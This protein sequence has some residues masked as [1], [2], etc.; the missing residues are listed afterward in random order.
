[1]QVLTR[2]LKHPNLLKKQMRRKISHHPFEDFMKKYSGQEWQN[3]IAITVLV[4]TGFL[5]SR[6]HFGF[7]WCLIVLAFGAQYYTNSVQRHRRNVRDDITRQL[8]I[9]KLFQDA[10][11]TEWLN[12]FVSKFW[13]IYEPVLSAMVVEIADGILAE[14][15]PG[16][17]DSLR[18]SHFTLGTKAPRVDSVKTLD[19]HDDEKVE[20]EWEFS[21]TPNDIIDMTK[22]ELERK[23]NPKICL[24]IRVGKGFVGAGIPVLVEDFAFKGR[25]RI[26]L[27]LMSTF[28]HVRT[29]D[30]SFME[31]P[32]IDYVLKPIGGETF[33][34]DIAHVPG[35]QTFI[36]DQT[37]AVL[38]P[39]M[40]APNVFTLDVA[41]LMSGVDMEAAV[42]VLKITVRSGR[43]LKNLE[44]MGMSDPYVILQ[45]NN[46]AE[47]GRTSVKKN[48]LNPVWDETYFILLHRLSDTLS[49]EVYD[50][51]EVKKDRSLGT[52]SFDLS[53][54]SESPEQVDVLAKVIREGGKQCGELLFD[55]AY[56]PVVPPIKN[57]D[58]TESPVESNSGILKVFVHQ[59]KGFSTSG[60]PYGILKLN[61]HEVLKTQVIKK[62][63]NPLWEKN[64]EMFISD[65]K[66][67][68]FGFEAY[69]ERGFASDP[70]TGKLNVTL[71]QALNRNNDNPWYDL[72]GS[73]GKVRMS[74]VWRP[75]VIKGGAISA[76]RL[77]PPLG[78]IRLDLLS[79]R[80]LKK[81]DLMG[82]SDPYVVVSIANKQKARTE[83]IEDNLDPTWNETHFIGVRNPL[84]DWDKFGKDSIIGKILGPQISENQYGEGTVKEYQPAI[85][86]EGKETGTLRFNAHFYPTEPIT[87][88][89]AEHEAAVKEPGND[90]TTEPIDY[91][92]YDTG[93]MSVLIGSTKEMRKQFDSCF[94]E[95]LL[96]NNEYNVVHRTEVKK[97]VT[98]P[99]FNEECEVFISVLIRQNNENRTVIART[100]LSAS[101]ILEHLTKTNS[102]ES[103]WYEFENHPGKIQ[104][105]FK[106]TPVN[107]E[108]DES[109]SILKAN[110]LQAAD[111][112]G[113]SDPFVVVKLNG[114]KIFKTK[115]IKKNLNPEFNE[116]FVA[117]LMARNEDTLFESLVEQVKEFPITNSQGTLTLSL[118]FT[119]EYVGKMMTDRKGTLHGAALGGAASVVGGT[120]G[121]GKQVVGGTLGAG[122]QVHVVGGTL[123]AGKQVVGGAKGLFGL[124]KKKTGNDSQ[125]MVVNDAAGVAS[126][127]VVGANEMSADADSDATGDSGPENAGSETT[128]QP[129]TITIFIL[130]GKD[131][132]AA[133]SNGMSDPYVKIRWGRKVVHKT[134]VIKKTLAPIWNESFTIPTNGSPLR[135]QFS[136]RD[137]NLLQD[138]ALGDYQLDVWERISPASNILSD[139]FMAPL[140]NAEKGQIK[141]RIEFSPEGGSHLNVDGGS[142]KFGFGSFRKKS[143]S[144]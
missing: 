95:V 104:L 36:R 130:E 140:A 117:S 46:R 122:K 57:E 120:L 83:V 30:V 79:A 126:A 32:L 26:V 139:E 111:S 28:P 55:V 86:H 58:G 24:E 53:T 142:K 4:F 115:T 106:F 52:A 101:E 143:V 35:L 102:N 103:S 138:T 134:K 135:L 116:E 76:G 50:K 124:G 64:V 31:P 61:G 137:H 91:T 90:L 112:S 114:E 132:P 72:E 45:C 51:E 121:A 78:V 21:F 118:L 42:G 10:E 71:E 39:M 105:A 49:L 17:L 96:N 63:D 43:N 37:N 13:L 84:Y 33:G 70:L 34:F 12:S 144:G 74:F 6:L 77:A 16:F 128:G 107:I 92:K 66:S 81:M 73:S 127:A 136:V 62:K 15:T 69:D 29:A 97:K 40:Y 48:T 38:G 87:T 89:Q 65:K 41:Q 67:A 141:L 99:I 133:D 20:M 25:M 2:R 75:V 119:P 80:K 94:A 11:S 131:L 125:E 1:M 7:G 47:L 108:I 123:G 19:N 56:S 88:P 85:R 22:R 14:N 113:L 129:G 9:N 5:V 68:L 93:L 98:D 82:K 54:L 44:F 3:Y 8:A 100:T 59:G 110:R 60:N 23:T 18:L 27:H 109:L